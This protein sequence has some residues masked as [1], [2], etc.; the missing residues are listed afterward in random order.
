[1]N[2]QKKYRLG[3]TDVIALNNVSLA[4]E[5]GEFMAIAGASGSGKST[6][7][8]MI[9]CIDTPD[10]GSVFINGKDT[11]GLS[12]VEKS[13]LR[14]KNIGFVFQTFNLIPVFN[15]IENV[16]LP[17]TIR[18]ELSSKDRRELAIAAVQAVGL[19]RFQLQVPDKLSG[20]QRQRVAIARA[21]VTSPSLVLADEPTANL[22]S[23]TATMI[24]DLMLELNQKTKVTFL[25]STHDEKL[26]G[27]VRR[28]IR[29]QDG[30]I[31]G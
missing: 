31:V 22:D 3:K 16:E 1:M 2:L 5:K 27:R 20:G 11:S 30:E 28:I 4:V 12:E 23:H 24:L 6:L 29:L 9:G 19:E 17:L 10:Q 7:L 15:I 13:S 8:N 18:P 25:F 14:N 21:L 26:M